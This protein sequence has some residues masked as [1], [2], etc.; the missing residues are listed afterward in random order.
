[1]TTQRSTLLVTGMSCGSC[2]QHVTTA[3][4]AVPG[5]TQVQVDLATGR[6]EIIHAPEVAPDAFIQAVVA[7]GYAARLAGAPA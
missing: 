2:R 7:A 4:Q 1:M 6:T 5:V 3:L